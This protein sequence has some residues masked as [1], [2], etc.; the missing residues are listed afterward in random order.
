MTP[1]RHYLFQIFRAGQHRAKSGALLEFQE[2]DLE[3]MAA[4]YN[5]TTRAAPL[6]LGHPA[7][8]QPAYGGV[9]GLLVK[10]GELYAQAHANSTLVELV[11][12]GRY[13]PVSASFF[14]PFS[15]ENPTPGA[16]YLK[17]VGFL[18]AMPPAV[19]GMPW[20]EFAEQTDSLC[21]C[22]GGNVR[23]CMENQDAPAAASGINSER[24]AL[25]ALAL[26]YQR[27]CPALSY[28]EAIQYAEIVIY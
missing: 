19:K 15:S 16:Y 4:A 13:G 5:P 14:P 25:H 3:L 20:P 12:A 22:E 27:A 28:S 18:G 24:G 9:L 2:D 21:F 17:H 8:D 6:V 1:Q 7:D 23:I 10:N 26:N 11:R